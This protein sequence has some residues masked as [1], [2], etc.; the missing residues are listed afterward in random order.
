MHLAVD[1]ALAQAL[2]DDLA[3]DVLA[4]L[5]VRNALALQHLAEFVGRQLVL[6]GDAQDRPLDGR[7]V[8]ADAGVLRKLQQ[9][10]LD[11]QPLQHL[12]VEH[13]ARTAA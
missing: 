6:L 1:L 7:V 13:V 4:I 5:G 3:P 11:D 10:A 8:D 9:R 2:D 12:L